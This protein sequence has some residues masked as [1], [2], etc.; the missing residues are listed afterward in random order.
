MELTLRGI[1][2]NKTR[3]IGLGALSFGSDVDSIWT[4]NS[5]IDKWIELNDGMDYFE[6]GQGYWIHSK[7]TDVWN[8]PL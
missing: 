8:V 2:T 7:V 6:I 5:T 3:D 4:Y 1:G